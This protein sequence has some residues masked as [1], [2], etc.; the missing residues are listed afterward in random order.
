MGLKALLFTG[1][2]RLPRGPR[3]L[4]LGQAL[5][6]SVLDQ[7]GPK[8]PRFG[9][10]LERLG[11]EGG[12]ASD[13]SLRPV[14]CHHCPVACLGFAGDAAVRG[15][16]GLL[17]ADHEGFVAMAEAAGDQVLDMLLQC[18]ELGLDAAAAGAALEQAGPGPRQ[19]EPLLDRDAP[20]SRPLPAKDSTLRRIF[21]GPEAGSRPPEPGT[22][23]HRAAAAM[24]LGICPVLAALCPGLEPAAFLSFLGQEDVS[25]LEA[26]LEQALGF[27]FS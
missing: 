26:G 8:T 3:D 27:L 19:L 21:L 24:V 25:G 11:P 4:S 10:V 6:R 22:A 13:K 2:G 23:E 17:L 5:V 7:C 12:A 15:Q 1:W 16:G 14:A 9:L 20:D 18:R